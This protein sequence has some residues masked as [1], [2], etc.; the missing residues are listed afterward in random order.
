MSTTTAPTTAFDK[1]R[2]TIFNELRNGTFRSTDRLF[3]I[4]MLLQWAGA[5]VVAFVVTPQ[6]WVGGAAET[7]LHVYAAVGLGGLITGVPAALAYLC[8]TKWYTRHTIAAA[9]L[10]M[11]ALL[12]HLT[13][14]R[15]ET[16]FHIFVSLAILSMY[17]DWPVLITGAAVAAADHFLRGFFWPE[18]IFGVIT[19]S[20]FRIFEHAGWVVVEVAF[21]TIGCL[22]ATKQQSEIATTQATTDQQQAELE[23]MMAAL[24][25][26]KKHAKERAQEAQAM[27][28][29][30][31]EQQQDLE[32]SVACML[33]HMQQFADGDLTIALP[34]DRS[35]AIGQ[36]YRGFNRA[37][38]N[39]HH[40]LVRVV[41]AV[42]QTRMT[43]DQLR[44]ASEQLAT[45]TEEQAAQA[46]E[47]AAAMAEMARTI[48]D[49][50]ESATR[51]AEITQTNGQ[52]AAES[53]TMVQQTVDKMNDIGRVV[54]SS[55][56]TIH[57]LGASSDEIGQIVQTIDEIADQ[58]NLLA[59]N[60]AIE[61]A[62]AGEHGKGFAVVADEVRLLAERTAEATREITTM[63]DAIQQ[64][65]QDAVEAIG[66]GQ[67]EVDTGIE[68]AEHVGE[69]VQGL[70]EGVATVTAQVDAI[71]S[72]TEEQSTTG[73]QISRSVVGISEVAGEA[74]ADVAEVA[75]AATELNE[76]TTALHEQV[77]GF[78][79]RTT[80]HP[81]PAGRRAKAYASA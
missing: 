79:L 15:I 33:D 45:G 61:A 19:G 55:A 44:A 68:L 64:E 62:R 65:T 77:S 6:T 13:G 73:E 25:E 35:D 70:V 43:A 74:A 78:K 10:L 28:T 38:D 11:S 21:L 12:I 20:E 23:D 16:H 76:L 39:I 9:Q 40:L 22:Q 2:T 56:E 57:R 24:H 50:A 54:A 52:T 63:I 75:Q 3:A 30:V 53:G 80:R 47:V 17:Q 27:A 7:H 36:L 8:P 60:A 72:A 31:E 67:S 46:D 59:F 81:Q 37:V 49:N 69:A 58:T 71:A 34:E 18:S 26:E 42:Q 48:E 1:R 14:G 41:E 66:A 29:R 32:Q 4:L 51:T 5:I